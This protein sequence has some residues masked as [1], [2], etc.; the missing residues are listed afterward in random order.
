MTDT[1]RR[2]LITGAAGFL[3]STLTHHLLA[4][5]WEVVGLDSLARGHADALPL[6]VPLVRGDVRDP[7]AVREAL[8]RLG[9]PP[10]VCFHLAGLIL[11]GE[12]V[13]Q[14]DLYHHVN[15]AG[16]QVVVDACLD[17]GVECV[18]MASSAGLFGADGGGVEPLDEDAALA[19]GS[20][21][22]DSKL[23]AEQ[24]L[25]A[26]VQTGRMACVALRLFNLAG[27]AYGC[28]ERHDPESHLIPLALQALAGTRPPLAVFGRDFPTPDGTCVRD[29]VHVQDACEA[30]L[31]SSTRAIER[32]RGDAGGFDVFHVGSGR[33]HSVLEV[34]QTCEE[35]TGQV[36]PRFDAPRREG[37]VARLVSCPDKLRLVLGL[38]PD[39][40]LRRMVADCAISMGL[41]VRA[42][43][44]AAV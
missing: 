12:S 33:G 32:Q 24:T 37:D 7:D 31:R 34:V 13:Q 9:R 36:V 6:T 17:H 35:V 39:R 40:D 29:Y 15:A 30:F 19:P 16:T 18:A 27:V 11:V 10:E 22:G 3:G 38:T 25:E 2:A 5:G 4:E 41:Q 44:A 14:P 21:Y 1:P 20:P 42:H 28:A 23:A 43:P 26:A 8:R